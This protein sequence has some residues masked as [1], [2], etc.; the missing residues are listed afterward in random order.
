MLKFLIIPITGGF[1]GWVT[2]VLAIKLIFWPY[3]PIKIPLLNL[4]FQGLIPKRRG[5]IAANIGQIIERELLSVDDLLKYFSSEETKKKF[6]HV[7]ADAVKKEIMTKIPKYIPTSIIR[8]VNNIFGD[9]LQ[10]EVPL[11]VERVSSEMGGEIKKGLDLAGIIEDKLNCF[12][13][14]TFEKLVIEI[15]NRELGHI[16]IMGAVLGFIIGLLQTGFVIFVLPIM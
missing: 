10:K 11:V 4:N 1:I 5:E 12:D 8:V 15:A 9:I 6:S 13:V 3:K 2:N 7:I 16:K 14:M